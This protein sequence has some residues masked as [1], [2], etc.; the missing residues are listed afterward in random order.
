MRFVA[1]DECRRMRVEMSQR[2]LQLH[3]YEPP[4]ELTQR[5]LLVA[6]SGIHTNFR[7]PREKLDGTD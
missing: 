7:M 3:R 4:R 5:L 6:Y 2:M 1:D